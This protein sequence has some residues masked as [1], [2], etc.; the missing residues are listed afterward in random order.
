M[1]S[2][3]LWAFGTPPVAQELKNSL[4]PGSQFLN[5]LTNILSDTKDISDA[6]LVASATMSLGMPNMV[7]I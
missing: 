5:R 6:V 7:S 1:T 2:K 3:P 4:E